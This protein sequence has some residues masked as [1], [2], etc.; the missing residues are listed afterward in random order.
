M[1]EVTEEENPVTGETMF[2]RTETQTP[3]EMYEYGTF[4]PTEWE[5]IPPAYFIPPHLEGV[6]ELLAAHGVRTTTVH[7]AP[8]GS[9]VQVFQ[10]DSLSTSEREYQGHRAQEVWGS[11]GPPQPASLE[12]GT[13]M[14]PMDQPLARVVFTL[15]EPRSDDGLV[16][17]GLL[18]AILKA[19]VDYP[20]SRAV[21]DGAPPPS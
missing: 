6:V 10:I 14:V 16:A 20:I 1:G 2:L 17:W 9:E 11:Y 15:L 18:S 12:P 13:V 5:T 21:Q 4:T 3:T 7:E 19:E 8:A